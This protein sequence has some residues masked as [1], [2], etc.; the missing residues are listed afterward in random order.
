M[1]SNPDSKPKKADVLTNYN[2]VYELLTTLVTDAYW[3]AGLFDLTNQEPKAYLGLSLGAVIFGSS[4][5]C[6]SA[7]GVAHSHRENN[8]F[9]Q[10]ERVESGSH[11]KKNSLEESLLKEEDEEERDC[12]G[13]DEESGFK[14]C[15]PESFLKRL[16]QKM[17]RALLHLNP[18][19][20]LALLG[21][22]LSH[23]G[24]KS[25]RVIFVT[26]LLSQGRLSHTAEVVLQC[27]AS[28]FGGI[29]ALS[30]VKTC[31]DS[32]KKN[33]QKG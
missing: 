1:P 11:E 18:L 16:P 3:L 5:A 27:G 13:N 4:L 10:T 31:R 12:Q 17:Q 2:A 6:L 28:F 25:G 21:A 22:W 29:A 14:S 20:E 26:K 23:A 19:E 8:I 33:A 9:H 24:L 32:M 15:L 30:D 7:W